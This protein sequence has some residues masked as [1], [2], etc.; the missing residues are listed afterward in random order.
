M[1][2]PGFE[3]WYA[4][5]SAGEVR[6]LPRKVEA[7]NGRVS[8]RVGK[9]LKAFKDKDGYLRVG[10]RKEGH[11]WSKAVHRLVAEAF[12]GEPAAGLE[13]DH[14]NFD[15]TDNRPC[16]LRWVTRQENLAHSFEANRNCAR[17]CPKKAKKLTA[18]E[19]DS[20]FLLKGRLTLSEASRQFKVS[21]S[22]VRG[23][24]NGQGWSA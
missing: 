23:I 9:I 22:V 20:I 16:N 3:G 11:N 7:R 19:A 1:A 12:L 5:S 10:L 21:C 24:W 14:R 8:S 13:V 6:S 18:A 15:K 17:T 2:V 4:V